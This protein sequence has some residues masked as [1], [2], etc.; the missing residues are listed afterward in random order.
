MYGYFL[1]GRRYHT[2]RR[3]RSTPKPLRDNRTTNGT[4]ANVLRTVSTPAITNGTA[5]CTTVDN[6]AKRYGKS[7]RQ[8]LR[9]TPKNRKVGHTDQIYCTHRTRYAPFALRRSFVLRCVIVF[10]VAH[11]CVQ[12]TTVVIDS[13]YFCIAAE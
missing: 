2:A 3:Q 7:Y 11:Y 13:F 12:Y 4:G 9:N 1:V 5:T 6:T 10:V 8:L